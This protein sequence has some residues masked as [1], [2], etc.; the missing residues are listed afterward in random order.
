MTKTDEIDTKAAPCHCYL[1]PIDPVFVRVPPNT[2]R[3]L[4]GYKCGKCGKTWP[5]RSTAPSWESA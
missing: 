3:H 5:A 4:V 2:Y 1:A